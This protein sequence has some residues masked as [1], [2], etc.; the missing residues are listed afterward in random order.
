MAFESGAIDASLAAAA[1]EDRTLIAELR[2]VFMA[3]ARRQADLLGRSRCDGNWRYTAWRLRALAASFGDAQLAALAD[4]AASGAPG[5][6][7][8]L[9][10]IIQRIE[11]IQHCWPDA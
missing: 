8:V 4:E 6:P 11:A 2:S 9:R 1:G 10:A 7:V 3:S 5:D